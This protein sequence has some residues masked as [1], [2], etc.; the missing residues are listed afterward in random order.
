[1]LRNLSGGYRREFDCISVC[2]EGGEAGGVSGFSV[3]AGPDGHIG[4]CLLGMGIGHAA[5]VLML[6]MFRLVAREGSGED[7]R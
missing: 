7:A 2:F 3:G 6:S 5:D 1:M 4:R